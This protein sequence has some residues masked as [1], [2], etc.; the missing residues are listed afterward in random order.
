MA[1][2]DAQK[3]QLLQKEARFW[4]E[5]EEQIGRLYARPHDWRFVPKLADI[6]IRPRVKTLLRLIDSH[7]GQIRSLLDVGCGNGWFCH[8]MAKRGIHSIGV[9]LSAKKIETARRDDV[10]ITFLHP[11]PGAAERE[12]AHHTRELREDEFDRHETDEEQL[13]LRLR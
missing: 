5:Q 13:L 12:I 6:I 1:D 2:H 4:D 10:S 9:D 11:V 3:Q 8:A 7:R